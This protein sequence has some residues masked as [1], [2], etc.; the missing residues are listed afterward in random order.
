[1]LERHFAP[2][3]QSRTAVRVDPDGRRDVIAALDAAFDLPEGAVVDQESVKQA[4]IRVFE[5]TFRVTGAL[6]ILT[7]GVAGF[8]LLASLMTL[9]TMRL[10]QVAPLWALGQTRARLARIEVGRRWRWCC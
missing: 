6:N 5:Q 9:S 10:P 8:A 3:D 4:S 1:M 2:I 7:L